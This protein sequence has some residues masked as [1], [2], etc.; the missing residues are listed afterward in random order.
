MNPSFSTLFRSAK[1]RLTVL[2]LFCIFILAWNMALSS[3]RKYF[4]GKLVH[5]VQ[6]NLSL[7]V[8]CSGRIEPKIQETIRAILDGPK[9][10][11]FVKEGDVVKKGQ[12]LMEIGE[13]T[14][15]IDINTKRT[16][17]RN[18]DV[19]YMKA[20]KD[21]ELSRRLFKQ[22]AIPQREVESAAQ[23]LERAGQALSAAREELAAVERKASGEKVVSPLD[24]VVLKNYVDTDSLV[25]TGKE[26]FK[27]AQVDRFI[28]RGHVDELEIA[29]ISLGQDAV[30][31]CDAFAGTEM[32]GKVAWIG[33]Q[34]AENAFADVPVIIDITDTQKLNLKANLSAE[35]KILIGEIPNAVVI[36][37]GAV[38]QSAKGS[39]VLKAGVG[40]WLKEQPITIDRTTSGQAIIKSGLQSSETVLVPSEEQ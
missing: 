1:N 40:G 37:A 18:A 15:R 35:A 7:H 6:Q 20:S 30:I 19:D 24:G 38:R 4:S 5:V 8:N 10:N 14:I 21:L 28:V 11:V 2:V 3:R 17:Y 13:D 29:Q 39:F 12:L 9:K 26:L 27:V 23:A 36:P 32:K 34:A 33:A 22:L 25:T 16:T 31:T